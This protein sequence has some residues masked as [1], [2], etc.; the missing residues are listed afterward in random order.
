M[1]KTKKPS[2]LLKILKEVIA[3]ARQA[4]GLTQEELAKAVCLSKWQ[5]KEM[6]E[7]DSFLIFY[8]MQIKVH[9][10]KRIGSYLGLKEEEYLQEYKK[11]S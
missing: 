10:A 4:K 3:Q 8:T 7:S 9:A 2:K 6:E 5:I 1:H 11:N